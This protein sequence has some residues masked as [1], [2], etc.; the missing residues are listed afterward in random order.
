MNL[1]NFKSHNKPPH[2]RATSCAGLATARLWAGRYTYG[3]T[4]TQKI[5]FLLTLFLLAG[6]S[7][8]N[9]SGQFLN[10]T[11]NQFVYDFVSALQNESPEN[12]SKL[13]L[14]PSK[15]KGQKL[16]EEQAMI[17]SSV[18]HATNNF[19][20]ILSVDSPKVLSKWVSVGIM[21]GSVNWW[22]AEHPNSQTRRYLLN[23]KYSKIGNGCLIILT[24]QPLINTEKVVSLSYCTYINNKEGIVATKKTYSD[25]FDTFGIPQDSEERIFMNTG[26]EQLLESL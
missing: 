10:S 25:I 1:R 21:A 20:Q 2:N 3:K 13:L 23:V 17:S 4:M 5:T 18:S 7:F 22:Y 24:N 14:Y 19:G 15:F 6:Q 12:I 9:T 8:A 26:F 11:P 16:S